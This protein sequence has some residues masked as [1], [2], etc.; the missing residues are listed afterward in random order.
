[1]EIYTQECEHDI[2]QAKVLK[3]TVSMKQNCLRLLRLVNNLIDITKI[4]AEAFEIHLKNWDIVYM[5][6]E[7]TLSVA[8]YMKNKGLSS[9]LTR[10]LK[11]KS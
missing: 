3:N 2:C 9:S 4:D 1:M 8:D 5:V 6:E 7:I 10:I 11:R